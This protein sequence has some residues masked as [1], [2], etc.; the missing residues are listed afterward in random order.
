[1]QNLKTQ[2]TS[3]HFRVWRVFYNFHVSDCPNYCYL[4]ESSGLCL[5]YFYAPHSN[6]T[7]SLAS[8]SDAIS[9]CSH[10]NSIILP[11]NYSAYAAPFVDTLQPG[12]VWLSYGPHDELSYTCKNY[13]TDRTLEDAEHCD[14]NN[15]YQ[16]ICLYNGML[17][18]M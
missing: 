13:T 6:Y 5:C 10:E 11:T 15:S 1:M 12:G 16:V 4:V 8:Q 14:P 9:M 18:Q 3:M 2:R 7:I 17:L